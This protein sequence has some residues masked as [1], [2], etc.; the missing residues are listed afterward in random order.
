MGSL[1]ILFYCLSSSG[2]VIIPK[3]SYPSQHIYDESAN[4]IENLCYIQIFPILANVLSVLSVFLFVCLVV[5][6]LTESKT[7]TCQ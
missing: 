6:L 2:M 5:S 1:F 3:V 7:A 4:I